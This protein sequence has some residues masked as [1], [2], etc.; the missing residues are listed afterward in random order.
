MNDE[1]IDNLLSEIFNSEKYFF[2]TDFK[3]DLDLIEDRN[4]ILYLLDELKLIRKPFKNNTLLTLTPLGIEVIEKG[5]WAKYKKWKNDKEETELKK[6]NTD[7][8]LAEKTLNEFPKTKW[9][10]RIGFFIGIILAI[11]QLIQWLMKL[12]SQ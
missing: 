7:L 3:D 1:I 11:V 9:F 2:K 4:P 12:Q 6:L 8:S 5:G 10:A